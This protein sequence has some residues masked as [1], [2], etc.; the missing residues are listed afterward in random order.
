[1]SC[2]AEVTVFAEKGKLRKITG[3]KTKELML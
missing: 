1:V 2:T 3:I